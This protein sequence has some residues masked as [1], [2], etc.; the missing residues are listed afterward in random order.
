VV[1]KQADPCTLTGFEELLRSA[2]ENVVRNAIRHTA[3]GTAVEISLSS[4]AAQAVI[5][6]R[7]YGPGVPEGM[8]TEIFLPFRR[9]ADG[10]SE[11]AGLG[12]AIAERAVNVHRGTLRASNA[13]Q[14]GL[15]V[16]I[17]LPLTA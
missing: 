12:L 6:V 11:G 3:E 14:G 1:I 9:V 2:V 4:E 16:E 17:D 5:R 15:I 7:D 8:L 10:N 13:P